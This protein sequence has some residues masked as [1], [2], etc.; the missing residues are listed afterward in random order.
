MFSYFPCEAWLWKHVL[1]WF[2]LNMCATNA[3]QSHSLHEPAKAADEGDGEK[4]EG[5]EEGMAAE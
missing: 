3:P 2:F 1:H 5:E 4:G